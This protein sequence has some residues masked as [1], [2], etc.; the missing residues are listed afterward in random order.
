MTEV[1]EF[2]GGCERHG[3]FRYMNLL[4]CPT[5]YPIVRANVRI[6]ARKLL[7]KMGIEHSAVKEDKCPRADTEA[8]SCVRE[9]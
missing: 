4:F 8:K 5:H 6:A 2:P 3:K 9:L 1:C 7:D